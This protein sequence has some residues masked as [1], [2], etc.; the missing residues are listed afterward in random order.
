MNPAD[1]YQLV[2]EKEGRLYPDQVVMHLPTL[3][4]NH[5]HKVEWEARAV[6]AGKLIRYIMRLPPPLFILELGCGNGWLSRRISEIPSVRIWGLDRSGVELKQAARLFSSSKSGFLS[7][8]IYRSPFIKKSFDI[9][10][11]ASVIQYFKDLTNLIQNLRSL[12]TNRGEIHLLDSP[13]YDRWELPSARERTITYYDALGFP[14]MAKHYFHHST[15]ELEKFSTHWLY[16][17]NRWQTRFAKLTG[18][19]T[20]PFPWLSIR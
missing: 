19:A 8:D 10:I 13:I 9:I 1:L 16:K 4:S 15:D 3:P 5:P 17:P 7:A 14:E 18:N 12:L 6:S 20:S 11:L 2:R